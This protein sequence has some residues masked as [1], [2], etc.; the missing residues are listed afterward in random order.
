MDA[1]QRAAKLNEEGR[2][3]ICEDEHVRRTR[4]LCMRHY[5]QY[6]RKRDSLRQDLVAS[7]EETLIQA[8]KL[9]PN[10]QGKQLDAEQDAFASEFEAFLAQN[11]DALAKPPKSITPKE[12]DAKVSKALGKST[13]RKN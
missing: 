5:E 2:C 6:R 1:K 13:K 3:I 12:A 11:P 9:M 10:R 8:G 4:G 7:W